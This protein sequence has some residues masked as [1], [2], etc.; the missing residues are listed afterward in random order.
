MLQKVVRVRSDEEALKLFGDIDKHIRFAEKQFDVR[1]CAR[2]HKITITGDVENS[3]RADLFLQNLLKAIRRGTSLKEHRLEE[4]LSDSVGI[5][6]KKAARDDAEAVFFTYKGK[7]IQARSQGQYDYIQRARE[8]DI[9]FSIGPAGTGKTY[10]AVALALELLKRRTVSRLIL[11]RPAVEAGENLGFLPGDIY[12]KIN[13]Y[14]RPLYDALYEM[15]GFDEV[16]RSMEKG[17]IEI[18]PL[19]YM[20]GRTLNDSFIILDEA[21]NATAEQMK[22]FLTRLG[23][24]SKCIV[25][26]DITQID[27]PRGN[28][29]GLVEVREVLKG[30]PGIHFSYLTEK[31]VVRHALV[32]DIIRAYE[33]KKSRREKEKK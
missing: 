9:I 11:T 15:I 20:R 29:S 28:V 16:S 18:A 4:F 30:I 3:E 6:G 24:S 12:A 10:L 13:P 32:K 5:K 8:Y 2:G 33:K 7:A 19:A 23:L 1:L 31:D 25:T 22:M 14:L 27:L 17:I 26:G 21:Q